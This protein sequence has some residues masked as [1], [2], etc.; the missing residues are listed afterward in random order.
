MKPTK[1]YIADKALILFNEKGFVNVRLQHIADSAFVSVGHLAYHFKNKEEII[2]SLYK[3]LKKKQELLLTEFRVLPLFE[4]IDFLLRNM[5]Q[6]QQQYRFFYLDT[7]EI[8]RAFPDIAEKHRELL[9]F[10]RQQIQ[11]MMEFNASRV[12]FIQPKYKA[13]FA[14]LS[15]IFCMTMDNWMSYQYING[16]KELLETA[17]CNDLWS[18]LRM[19]FT[20]MG[21]PEFRQLRNKAID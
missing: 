10:Q 15:H 21:E 16:N 8:L 4:D 2:T 11:F 3:R 7:L 6:L 14:E 13:Q 1:Q 17:Y 19:L 12:S 20:D 5:Y 18:V 9:R